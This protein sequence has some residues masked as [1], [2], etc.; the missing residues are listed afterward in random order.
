M[1]E[2]ASES[3]LPASASSFQCFLAIAKPNSSDYL[4]NI[5]TLSKIMADSFIRSRVIKEVAS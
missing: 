2:G 1:D 5:N 3:D 4:R